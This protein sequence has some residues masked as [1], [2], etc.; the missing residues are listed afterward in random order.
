MSALIIYCSSPDAETSRLLA[1]TLVEER[2]AA[3]VNI[4]PGLYSVYHWQNQIETTNEEL[5]LIETSQANYSAIEARVIELHPYELP[6]LIAV[7]IEQGLPAYL[8]WI[9]QHSQRQ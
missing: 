6:K 1:H 5:L 2:L 3:G 4:I 8:S 9:T 7:P